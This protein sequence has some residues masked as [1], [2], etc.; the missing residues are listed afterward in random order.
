MNRSVKRLPAVAVHG[1]MLREPD[2]IIGRP[3]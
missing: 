3:C 2:G 1:L